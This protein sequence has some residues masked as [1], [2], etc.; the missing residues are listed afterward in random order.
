[1]SISQA[2]GTPI[3]AT[4]GGRTYQVGLITQKIKGGLEAACKAEVR[5]QIMAD[6]DLLSADEFKLAY[7][8]FLD[9][10]GSGEF[11]FGGELHRRWMASPAGLGAVVRLCFGLSEANADALIQEHPAEVGKVIEQV[12][13]ESFRIAPAPQ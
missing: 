8:A 3:E 7:G 2:M 6:K 10:V 12:F 11:G 5:N 9:R 4:I 13:A 1:M